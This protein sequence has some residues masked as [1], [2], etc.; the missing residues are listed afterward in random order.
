MHWKL[1]ARN[2]PTR[3]QSNHDTNSRNFIRF[4]LL[5]RK[6]TPL[7]DCGSG[8]QSAQKNRCQT[9][10]L[11]SLASVAAPR[12]PI[13]GSQSRQFTGLT[14]WIDAA[15]DFG[16]A[17]VHRRDSEPISEWSFRHRGTAAWNPPQSAKTNLSK[18]TAKKYKRSIRDLVPGLLKLRKQ[19]HLAGLQ[20]RASHHA[21][22]NSL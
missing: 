13:I 15:L 9:G 17:A 4:I 2:T 3:N 16:L 5:C 18:S 19:R 8:H 20:S 22:Q 1:A 11:A 14:Y 10:F 7:P 6:L 12:P 21:P